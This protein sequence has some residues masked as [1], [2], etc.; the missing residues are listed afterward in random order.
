MEFKMKFCFSDFEK[1]KEN[2]SILD[3]AE[4]Y[5]VEI[6]HNNKALCPFHEEKTP[7]CV[8]YSQ[9]DS[10]NCFGCGVGGDQITLVKKL[11]NLSSNSEAAKK[12]NEDFG[13]NIFE[14]KLNKKRKEEIHKQI[15]K[16][17]TIKLTISSYM[18]YKN[19]TEQWFIK[20]Y[21]ILF[22]IFINCA[23]KNFEEPC[24]VWHLAANNI[25]PFEEILEDFVTGPEE[26]L[27][28]KYSII[29]VWQ[30]KIQKEIEVL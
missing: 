22:K 26:N 20:V 16:R 2:V 12:I 14:E 24:Q 7:S 8:F 29:N 27:L 23:P 3:I 1:I 19:R 18:T 30:H 25:E 10:F 11:F 28:D 5:R 15:Q 17:K 9:T 13:L 6:L 4:R 21:K